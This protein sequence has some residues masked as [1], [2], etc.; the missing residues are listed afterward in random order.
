MCIQDL[1]IAGRAT[2][3]GIPKEEDVGLLHIAGNGT[4]STGN[5]NKMT[6]I[7]AA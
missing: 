5:R 3:S 6:I 2:S 1:I 4:S 7:L